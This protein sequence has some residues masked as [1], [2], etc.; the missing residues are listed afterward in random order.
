MQ[1]TCFYLMLNLNFLTYHV[2]LVHKAHNLYCKYKRK[3][4][5]VEDWK[6]KRKLLPSPQELATGSLDKIAVIY[7]L[8]ENICFS[9]FYGNFR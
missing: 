1:Y 7:V 6:K 2:Q 3:D 5:M 8:E 4:L 9:P